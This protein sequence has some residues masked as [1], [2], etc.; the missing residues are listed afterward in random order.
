MQKK[1][2][3]K[4]IYLDH[5]AS[6][7]CDPQV[8]EAM[9]PYFSEYFANPSSSMHRAGKVAYEAV[10]HARN[11]IATALGARPNEIV[12]T[13]GATESNNLAVL[14]VAHRASPTRRHIV[15]CAVE[16]KSVL[17]PCK[18]LSS[19]GFEVTVLPVTADGVVSL[20]QLKEV[21]TDKTLLVSIQA[22]NNEIGTLQP[23]REISR[24]AH[25]QGALIHC[26]AAQAVGKIPID[27]VSLD[28]DLLSASAHKLYGPKGIGCLYIRDGARNLPISTVLY[29]GGQEYGIRPGTLNVPAIVGFARAVEL[30]VQAIDQEATRIGELR[31]QFEKAI[32][33]AL[34]ETHRNGALHHRLPGNCSLT[35]PGIEAEILIANLPELAISTGSAC[36]S[37]APEPSH[38]LLAI[39]LSRHD[40]FSTIRIGIGKNTTHEDV[41]LATR[42]IIEAVQRLLILVR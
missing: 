33:T 25:V 40:A 30:A 5:H 13:S 3:V 18:A 2:S 9:S 10:D 17:E 38:V 12:F 37:G 19:A 26:D 6:T 28:I 1:E 24:V 15:T 29:G 11:A 36:T 34:P 16:H 41:Q 21:V 39:G 42:Q 4:I 31:A 8:V 7:P 35:I 32:L 14:G 23:I 27:V 22:A 20:S